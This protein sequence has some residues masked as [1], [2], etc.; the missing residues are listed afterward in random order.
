MARNLTDEDIA[1]LAE[2]LKEGHH[3]SF[4]EEDRVA[5]RMIAKADPN[6]IVWL[7][8]SYQ[9]ATGYLWKGVL[10]LMLLGAIALVIVGAAVSGKLTWLTPWIKG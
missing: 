4:R 9:G 7:A 3:C 8:D 10:A 5:L 1:A 2:A 6:V